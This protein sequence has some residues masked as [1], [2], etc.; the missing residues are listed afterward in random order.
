LPGREWTCRLKILESLSART[1]A[2][3]HAFSLRCG[4]RHTRGPRLEF[5]RRANLPGVR[6][7]LRND[8]GRSRRAYFGERKYYDIIFNLSSVRGCLSSPARGL[9][10]GTDSELPKIS[11]KNWACCAMCLAGSVRRIE[12]RLRITDAPLGAGRDVT[13]WVDRSVRVTSRSLCDDMQERSRQQCLEHKR[14][15]CAS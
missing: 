9:P 2:A 13:I 14:H 11:G 10:I 8:G 12:H 4:R 6:S 3:G 15:I 1:L 5:A 7:A